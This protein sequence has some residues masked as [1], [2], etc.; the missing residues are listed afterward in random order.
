MTKNVVRNARAQCEFNLDWAD[1][2][3]CEQAEEGGGRG[4]S[5]QY[6]GSKNNK[7]QEDRVKPLWC[8]SACTGDVRRTA[9]GKLSVEHAC[10]AC[11]LRHAKKLQAARVGVP[12][13]V[14][15]GPVR[16]R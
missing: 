8:R 13:K 10:P 14:L 3:T 2:K 7:K 5:L 11:L 9:E 16:I 1:V 15:T 12:I 4:V 6:Q